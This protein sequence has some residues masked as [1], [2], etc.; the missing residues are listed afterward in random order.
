[1][2]ERIMTRSPA[3]PVQD[4]AFFCEHRPHNLMISIL[5]CEVSQQRVAYVAYIETRVVYIVKV[6]PYIITTSFLILYRKGLS[7]N[8]DY[9]VTLMLYFVYVQKRFCGWQ[10]SRIARLHACA[11]VIA[12]HK[13][14]VWLIFGISVSMKIVWHAVVHSKE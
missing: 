5:E 4:V 12:G 1:M 10:C 7:R 11:A 3:I 13:I 8:A 2:N 9:A 14:M 6:L